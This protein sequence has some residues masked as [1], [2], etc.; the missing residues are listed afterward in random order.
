[1]K[2][3]PANKKSFKL[4]IKKLTPVVIFFAIIA[5]I[6]AIY[7]KDILKIFSDPENIKSYIESKGS[8]GALIYI[9]LQILQ[10]VIAVIPGEPIQIAGGY[11]FGTF[12]GFLYAEIGI[13]AG[14]A[15]AFFIARKF[16]I[17]IIRLF[18]SE[19]KLMQYKEKLESKKGLAIT[20]LLCLIP[21]IPKD[22]IV[23]AS[24][25]TPISY[26]LFF[27]IYFTARL[28]A[29]LAASYM[30]AA[31]GKENYGVFAV[32]VA[33]AVVLLILGYIFKDKIYVLMK[34]YE[35]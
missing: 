23:Y 12:K 24:G 9:A 22:I 15:I 27:F 34:K 18:V 20:F 28:P 6:F 2:N 17:P 32:L 31:L 30:G 13:M 16:G 19:K 1:M 26:R 11:I 3:N 29:I 7:G 25:L 21:G 5:A 35:E 4:I 10:I 8:R 14:S 33:G